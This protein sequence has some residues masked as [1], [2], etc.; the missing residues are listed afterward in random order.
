MDRSEKLRFLHEF[1]D[2]VTKPIERDGLV[3]VNHVP[4]QVIT[5]YLRR[6]FQTDEEGEP[7]FGLQFAIA[8]RGRS[9]RRRVPRQRALRRPRGG[10]SASRRLW[11][12]AS[13]VRRRARRSAARSR[14]PL[15]MADG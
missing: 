7:V 3:H 5:E 12:Y 15:M 8:R 2:D 9:Q 14:M 11:S 10:P 13:S 6:A 1:R 4:T